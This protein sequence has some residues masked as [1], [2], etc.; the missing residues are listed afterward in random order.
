MAKIK[1]LIEE[2]GK[3]AR[4]IQE[5]DEDLQSQVKQLPSTQ[6]ESLSGKLSQLEDLCQNKKKA[7]GQL[8]EILEELRRVV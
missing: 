6:L 3:I 4:K 5:I 2:A 8:T 1:D 7:Y